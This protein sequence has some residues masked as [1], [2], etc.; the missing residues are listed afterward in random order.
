MPDN[1][2]IMEKEFKNQGEIVFSKLV[3]GFK[4]DADA[5][6]SNF[7]KDAHIEYPYAKALGT[8]HQLNYDEYFVYLVQALAHLPKVTY[9]NPQVYQVDDN[10]YWAE[11]H[12]EAIIP[13]TGNLYEQNYVMFFRL[14]D[15]LIIQ[16]KEYWDALAG[17]KAME[18][19]ATLQKSLN[20]TTK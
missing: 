9:S 13:S 14:K 18:G 8:P 7:H 10:T 17:I 5:I 2:K 12:A 6:I 1:F 3:Q 20:T 15:G 11:L 4:K 19:E 16:Y